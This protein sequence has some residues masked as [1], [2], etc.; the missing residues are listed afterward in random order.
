MT[1]LACQRALFAWGPSF[2]LP[3]VFFRFAYASVPSYAMQTRQMSTFYISMF[4]L[5]EGKKSNPRLI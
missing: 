3:F 5:T 4:G 1:L 2:I